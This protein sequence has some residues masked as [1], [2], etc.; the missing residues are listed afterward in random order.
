MKNIN[1]F[2]RIVFENRNMKY[3]AYWLRSTYLQRLKSATIIVSACML[4]LTLL[5]L[6]F[7]KPTA[8]PHSLKVTLEE[9]IYTIE[10]P[11]LPELKQQKQANTNSKKIIGTGVSNKVIS[12][13]TTPVITAT[14]RD[15]NSLVNNNQA[16][17]GTQ[18]G[19]G[20]TGADTSSNVTTSGTNGGSNLSAINIAEEMP[21]FPGGYAAL[22]QF[23]VR[24]YDIPNNVDLP[25]KGFRIVVNFIVNEKGEITN[26]T[27]VQGFN[28]ACEK[29]ALRVLSKMPSWKPGKQGGRPVNVIYNLPIS[30]KFSY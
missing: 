17:G 7:K 8:N 14:A 19:G 9:K 29:E 15:T 28:A 1:E 6:G 25:E 12:A 23:I 27:V 24:N 18:T 26:P 11:P 5:F 16:G 2:D 22:K 4:L 13:T 20:A 21:E 30:I 3:G 10:M